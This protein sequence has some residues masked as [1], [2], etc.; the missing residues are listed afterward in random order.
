MTETERPSRS[1]RD[2]R[3]TVALLTAEPRDLDP[4]L[5]TAA[6]EPLELQLWE[7]HDRA[8]FVSRL[9]DGTV[10]RELSAGPGYL[11]EHDHLARHQVV[12]DSFGLRRGI[13]IVRNAFGVPSSLEP[14]RFGSVIDGPGW[15]LHTTNSG[16]PDRLETNE[17]VLNWEYVSVGSISKSGPAVTRR[18][19]YSWELYLTRGLP[20]L[21][22]RVLHASWLPHVIVQSWFDGGFLYASSWYRSTQAHL[23]WRA[24]GDEIELIVAD[25]DASAEPTDLPAVVSR[26]GPNRLA[27]VRGTRAD[28]VAAVSGVLDLDGIVNVPERMPYVDQSIGR[29]RLITAVS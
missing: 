20:H 10:I 8:F 6:P 15:T 2:W 19:D 27:V 18:H 14:D 1:E 3:L 23:V 28:L 24:D 4:E 7:S 17:L 16:L 5:P 21:A 13:D 25:R 29:Y 12:R 22:N 9:M 11:R 26:V